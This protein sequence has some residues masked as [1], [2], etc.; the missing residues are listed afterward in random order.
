MAKARSKNAKT[1]IVLFSLAG[2]MVGLAFASAPLYKLFCQIT[3]YGGTPKIVSEIKVQP[4]ERTITVRF[5]A[6]VNSALPWRFKPQQ[7]QITV[8][9]GVPTQISYLAKNLSGETMTGTSSFNVTPYK[10]AK[11]FSKIDCFCFTKQI[12]APGEEASLGVQF[13]VDP[14]IFTDLNTRELNT[15]TLSYTFY[16]ARGDAGVVKAKQVEAPA[17]LTGQDRRAKS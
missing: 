10:A 17:R 3:G 12:L 5:D 13:Y 16:R 1:A 9:G 6:N 14:E 4:S 2:G 11:Y 7:R 15:I 8:N